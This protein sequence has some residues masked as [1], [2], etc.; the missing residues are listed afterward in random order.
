MVLKYPVF[1]EIF[2]KNKNKNLKHFQK[3]KENILFHTTKS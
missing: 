2:Q 3:E 1:S